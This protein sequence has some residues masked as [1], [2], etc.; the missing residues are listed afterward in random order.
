MPISTDRLLEQAKQLSLPDLEYFVSELITLQARRKAPSLS[1]EETALFLKINNGMSP[2]TY[3]RYWELIEKRR[4][5]S[6]TPSEYEEL[7]R[8]SDLSEKYQVERL[9]ALIELSKLRKMSLTDLMAALGIT[10]PEVK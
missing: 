9:E 7:L 5:E 3:R 8:L 6:L 2:E 4:E 1:E 10:P